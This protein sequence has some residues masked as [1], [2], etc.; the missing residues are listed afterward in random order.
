MENVEQD[1]AAAGG[2]EAG[3]AE[4]PEAGSQ[5][6][7]AGVDLQR[8]V[9]AAIEEYFG[10][11]KARAEPVYKTELEEE[12]RRREGLERRVS[13]LTAENSRARAAA[14]EAERG[15][16]VRGELQRLGV[17]KLDLAYRAVKDDIGRGEDGRLQS[18]DGGEMKEYLSRFVA[19][20][21][22]LLPGR[23]AGGSGASAGQK[24]AGGSGGVDLDHIRPGMS[25]EDRERARQEI[26]RVASQT[27]KGM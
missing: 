3:A 27:L 14:E 4:Q 23:L 9:R 10:S 19:E 13:E 22:E 20:N 24:I 11:E 16:A 6:E 7:G 2:R 5:A 21:P 12:R 17:A 15:A 8:L 1:G 25:A 18:R 26:A